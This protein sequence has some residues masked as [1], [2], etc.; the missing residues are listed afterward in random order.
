MQ[1]FCAIIP[2]ADEVVGENQFVNLAQQAKLDR[3][4]GTRITTKIL[5]LRESLEQLKSSAC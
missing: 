4:Y 1:S 3:K 5:G 2:Y